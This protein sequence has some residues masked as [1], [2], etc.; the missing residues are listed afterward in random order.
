MKS[1][2]QNKHNKLVGENNIEPGEQSEGAAGYRED[3]L[4]RGGVEP[5]TIHISGNKL[6]RGRLSLA[7]SVRNFVSPFFQCAR[8]RCRSRCAR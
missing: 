3:L 5:S 8:C 2:T 4:I 6:H 7:I 1:K